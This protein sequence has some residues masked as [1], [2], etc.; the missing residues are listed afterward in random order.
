MPE[1]NRVVLRSVKVNDSFDSHGYPHPLQLGKESK[2]LSTLGNMLPSGNYTRDSQA[3]ILQRP[4]HPSGM[5]LL[6]PA[7][8]KNGIYKIAT[9]F[10]V[11]TSKSSDTAV[12]VA[13]FDVAHYRRQE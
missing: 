3:M 6:L 8:I 13:K 12:R 1:A 10:N 9:P 5:K 7:D 2:I 4:V 11:S